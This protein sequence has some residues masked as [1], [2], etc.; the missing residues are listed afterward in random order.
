MQTLQVKL[1]GVVSSSGEVIAGVPQSGVISPTLFNVFVNDIDDCCPPGVS[2]STCKYADDCTQHELVPTG[3]DSHTQVKMGNLE[4]WAVRNKM[5][6]NAK[7]T[8]EMWVSFR[9]SQELQA[10]EPIRI[11]NSE[12]ERELR[13]SNYL[14]YMSR[15]T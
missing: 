7:K 8:K 14:K 1:P 2:I 10:P 15:A 3:S 13:S 6:I 12:I 5:E 4:A 11:R 9:K